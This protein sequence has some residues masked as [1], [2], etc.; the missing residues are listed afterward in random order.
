MSLN[1]L[2]IRRLENDLVGTYRVIIDGEIATVAST[3]IS[4]RKISASQA[5]AVVRDDRRSLRRFP[6]R[7]EAGP[8]MKRF[9]CDYPAP[10]DF[11]G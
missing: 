2:R 1:P 6:A 5:R 10:E 3:T 9:D 8:E 11:L 4:G 7:V